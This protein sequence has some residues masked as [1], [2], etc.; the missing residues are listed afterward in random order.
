VDKELKFNSV[1]ITEA[2][3][4]HDYEYLVKTSKTASLSMTSEASFLELDEATGKVS[5]TAGSEGDYEV[6]VE[7]NDGKSTVRQSYVLSV[8]A[9]N[10]STPVAI[11]A[12]PLGSNAYALNYTT[13]ASID[14]A[15]VI[16]WDLGDGNTSTLSAPVHTYADGDYEVGLT[17]VDDDGKEH[18]ASYMLNVNAQDGRPYV[19]NAGAIGFSMSNPAVLVA[20]L[21]Y[22]IIAG[23]FGFVELKKRDKI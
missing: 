18:H 17:V 10:S 21:I 4:G 9:N 3:A 14:G 8:K 6:T 20:I 13:D 16:K 1:P 5:G 12:T 23:V 7:A 19:P 2:T 15:T 22:G 11:T